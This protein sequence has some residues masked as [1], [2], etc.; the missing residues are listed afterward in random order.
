M[1]IVMYIVVHDTECEVNAYKHLR[2]AIAHV[3][4]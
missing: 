1:L 3:L 4:F 2:F